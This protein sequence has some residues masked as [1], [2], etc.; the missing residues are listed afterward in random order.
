MQK[1]P[2]EG[3]DPEVGHLSLI[4]VDTD[5]HAHQAK[6]LLQ[7]FR[8][9]RFFEVIGAIG[10]LMNRVRQPR[11]SIVLG[12]NVWVGT[13]AGADELVEILPH[14]QGYLAHKKHLGTPVS[15]GLTPRAC[16]AQSTSNK[17][18][19]PQDRP[20]G[21]DARSVWGYYSMYRGTSLIRNS[22]P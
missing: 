10:A 12:L 9:F 11:P 22:P 1:A 19:T 6:S 5:S 20:T 13:A 14:V 4:K 21:L 7:S 15:T 3:T 16:A 2:G 18:S 17:H 8:S